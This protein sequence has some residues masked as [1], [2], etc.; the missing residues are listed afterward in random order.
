M[1]WGLVSV[2]AW[3]MVMAC[4]DVAEPPSSTPTHQS[5]SRLKRRVLQGDGGVELHEEWVDTALDGLE[6]RF[7]ETSPGQVHCLPGSGAFLKYLDPTC[8]EPVVEESR[9]FPQR[10]LVRRKPSDDPCDQEQEAYVAQE[11]LMHD[12][13]LYVSGP[14][15]CEVDGPTC[16][17]CRLYHAAPVPLDTFVHAPLQLEERGGRLQAE[18]FETEDGARGIFAL[19]DTSAERR[20]LPFPIN[21]QQVCLPEPPG[22]FREGGEHFA[23]AACTAPVVPVSSCTEEPPLFA[24]GYSVQEN[25]CDPVT[26]SLHAVGERV[27]PIFGQLEGSCQ[28]TA[29]HIEGYLVGQPL[30]S[31]NLMSLAQGTRGDGALRTV[32]SLDPNGH[33]VRQIRLE[34][35]GVQCNAFTFSDPAIGHRCIPSATEASRTLFA[36]PACG[37]EPIVAPSACEP[38]YVIVEDATNEACN[39]DGGTVF[40]VGERYEGDVYRGYIDVDGDPQCV[41]ATPAHD[42]Y[43]LGAEVDP[44]TFP[45]LREVVR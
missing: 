3:L 25:I 35:D 42:T 31:A 20:C 7:R 26:F 33:P 36:D 45:V 5:G 38:R 2:A 27:G 37:G 10:Y 43:R 13:D 14:N 16:D 4:G 32:V 28:Q 12:G 1:R 8:T 34:L 18:T 39:I 40:E 17:G 21:E 22:F 44:A 9:C 6:C 24:I 23:D 30:P 29:T 41:P 11:P 15:G 19:K